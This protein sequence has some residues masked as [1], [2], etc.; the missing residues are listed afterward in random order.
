MKLPGLY[1]LLLSSLLVTLTNYFS[2]GGAGY[3]WLYAPIALSVLGVIGKYLEV[4]KEPEP[5]QPN[6]PGAQA[7][8]LGDVVVPAQQSK[9]QRFLLG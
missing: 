6:P 3:E 2:A 7:R 9:V 1:A 5:T 4:Q 8:G